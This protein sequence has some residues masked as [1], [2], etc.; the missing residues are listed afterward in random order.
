MDRI[1]F[2]YIHTCT[3]YSMVCFKCAW[4]SRE[5]CS[6]FPSQ[7]RTRKNTSR[8]Q[9]NQLLCHGINVEKRT[10]LR[11]NAWA[12]RHVFVRKSNIHPRSLVIFHVV[13]YTSH[14]FRIPYPRLSHGSNKLCWV[15]Q[16][17]T[18]CGFVFT[19]PGYH[20]S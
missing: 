19:G 17:D 16:H 8:E 20:S 13:T 2:S 7:E 5:F 15:W 4:M 12:N 14:F 6:V 18:S 9:I 3:P 1:H 11:I 10:V